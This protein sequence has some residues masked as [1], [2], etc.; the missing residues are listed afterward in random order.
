MAEVIVVRQNID[1]ETEFL[2]R[3]EGETELSAVEDIRDVT[4]YG[5]LLAS[6]GACSAVLV[7]TYA[8]HHG[9]GLEQ[10]EFRVEYERS[11]KK[12]CEHCEETQSFDEQIKMSVRFKGELDEAQREKLFKI[13][14]QCPVHKILEQGIR[15]QTM[16]EKDAPLSGQTLSGR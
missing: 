3:F 5:M 1:F 13:S 10:T 2:A 7:N 6:L 9:L 8:Q 16:L 4:P 11:F 15:V 14:L 12:D